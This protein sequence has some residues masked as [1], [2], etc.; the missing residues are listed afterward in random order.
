MKCVGF[1]A[2]LYGFRS[3]LCDWRAETTD[4][5]YEIAEIILGVYG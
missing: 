2:C 4:A 1:G 3:S 5:L